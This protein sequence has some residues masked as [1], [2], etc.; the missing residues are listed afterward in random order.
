MLASDGGVV[1]L[2][3]IVPEDADK[4]VEFHGKLSERTRYLRYF[5]PYPTISKRDLFNFTV[6]DHRKRVAFVAMLGDEIIA[7]GRYEGLSSEGDGLSAEVAFT[8]SDSHQGAGWDPSCSSISRELPRRTDSV[9]SL[10]RSSQR[11]VT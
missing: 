10:P 9:A 8:V 6:V 3:P 4:I 7:V 11:T 2:R 1:H 5:G